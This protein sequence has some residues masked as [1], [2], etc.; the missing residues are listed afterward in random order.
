MTAPDRRNRPRMEPP[1][2]VGKKAV[3]VQLAPDDYR[4]LFDLTLTE[5]VSMADTIRLLIRRA[6]QPETT[7]EG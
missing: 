5:G 7:P 4:R 6:S 1:R 3:T 2:K